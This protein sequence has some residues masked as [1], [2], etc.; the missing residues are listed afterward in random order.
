MKHIYY[1]LLF[2]LI[3]LGAKAQGNNFIILSGTIINQDDQLP[4]PGASVTPQAK[5]S[6]KA[7]GSNVFNTKYVQYAGGPTLGGLYYLAITFDGLLN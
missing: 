3:S 7:G 4:L 5:A 1:T 6:I 2:I